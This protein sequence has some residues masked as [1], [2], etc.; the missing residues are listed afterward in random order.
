MAKIE[1]LFATAVFQTALAVAGGRALLRSL[2]TSCRAI[3]E[4]DRAGQAWC[5]AN[6]YRGYTSYASLDDLAWRDPAF[7]ELV[8]HLDGHVAEFSRALDHDLAGRRLVCDSLWVNI[9]EPGGFHTAHIHPHSV[10]SGTVYVAV[11]KGASAIRFEDPRLAMLMAAP[12]KRASAKRANR[13]F[14]DVAPEPGTV[15]LWESFLRHEVP[16]NA[17]KAERISISFNYALKAPI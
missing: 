10:I 4:A 14:V 12:P 11:P 6:N 8:R 13:T 7:A 3:A 2:D 5:A 1:S 17:A 16:V 15:L 9:L